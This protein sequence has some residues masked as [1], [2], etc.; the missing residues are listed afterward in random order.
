M[1]SV[2]GDSFTSGE[3]PPG[4]VYIPWCDLLQEKLNKK[5]VNLNR[6]DLLSDKPA[7]VYSTST[8]F[9]MMEKLEEYKSI[10][11]K[12]ELFI[13]QWTA[14]LRDDEDIKSDTPSIEDKQMYSDLDYREKKLMTMCWDR[15]CNLNIKCP[16][17]FWSWRDFTNLD[18][19]WYNK[20]DCGIR[21]NT[22]D[23]H[24]KPL[25]VNELN[26]PHPNQDGH[27]WI[28]E[29]ILRFI[30]KKNYL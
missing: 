29:E 23:K 30:K 27:E 16:M 22:N 17:I 25:L 2:I 3:S 21:W 8:N 7:E 5:V 15:L 11:D 1:I 26:D 20:Y 13:F 6:Q 28:S 10:L 19:Y 18:L 24:I 4:E 9:F 12:S 14:P